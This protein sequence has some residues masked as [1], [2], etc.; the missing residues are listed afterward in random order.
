MEELG[1]PLHEKW[2][3][4]KR[5][6]V[7][8]G[9]LVLL[10]RKHKL[11]TIIQVPFLREVRGS[12]NPILRSGRDAWPIPAEVWS[13]FRSIGGV[14]RLGRRCNLTIQVIP[15]VFRHHKRAKYVGR[16]IAAVRS[17][18]GRKAVLLDPDTGIEPSRLTAE[19]VGCDEVTRVWQALSRG[20]WL[21]LYQHQRRAA[22]WLTEV[23]EKFARACDAAPTRVFVSDS[24]RDVAFVAAAKR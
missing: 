19:H 18:R 13:H 24:A 5:D 3:A 12:D 8:W 7:K 23:Q 9:T 4:D 2:Y 1:S 22:G 21:V 11:R 10:A 20:D 15:D 14:T 16:V 17:Q 6:V